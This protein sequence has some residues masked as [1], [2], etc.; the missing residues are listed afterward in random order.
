M[1]NQEN[2]EKCR[3]FSNNSSYYGRAFGNCLFRLFSVFIEFQRISVHNLRNTGI[4]ICSN[5]IW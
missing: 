1:L 3:R 4:S 5:F 2:T